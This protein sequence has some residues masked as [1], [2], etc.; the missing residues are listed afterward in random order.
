MGIAISI[1]ALKRVACLS[2]LDGGEDAIGFQIW[3]LEGL[4]RGGWRG[5]L[6]ECNLDT[7]LILAQLIGDVAHFDEEVIQFVFEIR[8]L[9]VNLSNDL[10][11]AFDAVTG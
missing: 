9:K 2:E 11:C 8:A 7:S 5:T 3:L 10:L 6:A 1:L 4:S